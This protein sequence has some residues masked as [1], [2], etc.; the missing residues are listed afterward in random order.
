M[1]P[2]LSAVDPESPFA[3]RAVR[4]PAEIELTLLM[5]CL[6]EARTVGACVEKAR[7]FLAEHGIAGEVLV[8]DN[9]SRDGSTE[10]AE[11]HGARVV[12]ASER[13]YGAALAAGIA[14]ARGRYVIMGDSDDSYDWSN[15]M[16]FVSALR[17]GAELV[18][19][20][21]YRGGIEK[22][23][24][25]F[26]HRYLG[27]PVLTAIGRRF[28]R[29]E[30]GDFYCG[31]RG[32]TREAALRMDLRSTGMEFALEMLVKASL[33]GMRV[34]EVPI[35]LA[36]DGRG[37]RSH[38]RT[39]RDG[40]RSLRFFLLYSPRWLFLVPGLALM[41]AGLAVGAWILPGPR[42][43]GNVRFDIHTLL[44]C[45]VAI[46][47]GF[48]LTVFYLFG[49]VLAVV[50]GLHPSNPRIARAMEAL[51]L[52]HGLVAGGLLFFGGL[53]GTVRAA[54]DWAA[55]RFGSLDPFETMRMTIPAALL[56]TL[57]A[58]VIFW[59]FYFSL[60]KMQWRKRFEGQEPALAPPRRDA[61]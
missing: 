20:N 5:P 22:G 57:G 13:G 45:W 47:L 9:G 30:C 39:W 23:A 49:K 56:T 19:G 36:P 18:M 32:F 37:R 2:H 33:L 25:P 43:I 46:S 28:F 48:Q 8:A 42:T 53:A 29:S 3:L 10:V 40:W 59:S 60:L 54:L 11:R 52:E 34:D 17:G 41:T 7:A 4:A 31:Q 24:M 15:L 26:L 51:H 35:V 44:Y 14:A 21:R 58:Q 1:Q 27:N 38:L 12:H 6:D 55:Q 16:P 50:S 61:A